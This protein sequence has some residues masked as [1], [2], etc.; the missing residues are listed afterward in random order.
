[1]RAREVSCNQRSVTSPT[2]FISSN[3]STTVAYSL[4][5]SLDVQRIKLSLLSRF[6][7]QAVRTLW[8]CGGCRYQSVAGGCHCRHMDA[9]LLATPPLGDWHV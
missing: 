2:C 3:H 5:W 1:M 7:R 6:F 8:Q 9:S 4:N